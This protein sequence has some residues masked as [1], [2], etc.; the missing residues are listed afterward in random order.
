MFTDSIETHCPTRADGGSKNSPE[1][2]KKRYR[3]GD[4]RRTI[5]ANRQDQQGQ[6]DGSDRSKD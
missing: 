2:G 5:S 6:R 1:A 3:C 4:V